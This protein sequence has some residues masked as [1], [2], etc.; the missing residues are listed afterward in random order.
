MDDNDFD[1]ALRLGDLDAPARL[2]DDP[3]VVRSLLPAVP[4]MRSASRRR[5]PS[6]PALGH[7]PR[8]LAKRSRSW[9]SSAGNTVIAFITPIVDGPIVHSEGCF[10]V[11]VQ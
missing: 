10:A 3:E 6:R 11:I 5:C 8:R 1:L 7:G 4:T 9:S 2:Y